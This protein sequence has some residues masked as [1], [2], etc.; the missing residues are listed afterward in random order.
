[1][2]RA[3][4]ILIIVIFLAL[5]ANAQ[6]TSTREIYLRGSYQPAL[7]TP[8]SARIYFDIS[9]GTVRISENGGSYTNIVGGGGGSGDVVGPASAT[10]NALAR[11]DLATGKLLQNSSATLSD[12]GLLTATSFAGN[13]ASIT[14]LNASNLAS[15]TVSNARLDAE[16]QA[17]AGLNSAADTLPYFT[18]AGTATTTPLTPFARTL[19]DDAAAVNARATLGLVIGT[20]VQAQD[21]ELSVIAG[22]TS[23]AD[24]VPYFTGAGTGA[25]A[26]FTSYGRSLVAVADEAAFK[27]LVNLEPGTDVQPFNSGLDQ[28]AELADPDADRILF[29]DDS[30]GAY[31]Y[32]SV[33]SG[34]SISGTTLSATGGGGGGVVDTDNVNWTGN[35][36]FAGS[37][38]YS[39]ALIETPVEVGGSSTIA[40]TTRRLNV[41][42]ASGNTQ[43]L[44]AISAVADGWMVTIA[45]TGG[46]AA[47]NNITIQRAGSDT[48]LGGGTSVV[49]S[50]NGCSAGIRKANGVWMLF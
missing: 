29:W 5:Q 24:R 4:F 33:G 1:M 10:D 20:D 32:L 45:D 13:G 14:S 35:H 25:L 15:G 49:I 50:C 7:S 21:T 43:T 2:K 42:A 46:N 36:S 48:F 23:A 39:G 9:T 22:L 47:T 40:T 18:G 34:L 16:L 37:T 17:L 8:G 6:R 41:D 30:A 26:V 44:P 11:W 19:L 27:A 38:T 31:V 3:V 12:A 28:I